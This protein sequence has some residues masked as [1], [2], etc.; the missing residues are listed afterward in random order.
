M[1]V[2]IQ[3]CV[4][5]SFNWLLLFRGAAIILGMIRW[6]L[7]QVHGPSPFH[8]LH[9][10][11]LPPQG[12]EGRKD[13]GALEYWDITPHP[14]VLTS[15]VNHI[16]R[17]CPRTSCPLSPPHPFFHSLPPLTLSPSDLC[18]SSVSSFLKNGVSSGFTLAAS[19]GIH[20]YGPVHG[21]TLKHDQINNINL[22]PPLTHAIR[23]ACLKTLT[24]L[25]I[26]VGFLWTSASS[27]KTSILKNEIKHPVVSDNLKNPG[28][29]AQMF[30]T[31]VHKCEW[32]LAAE[33]PQCYSFLK[34]SFQISSSHFDVL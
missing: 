34:S 21:G 31:L 18:V 17:V 27:Y 20:G 5:L 1:S 29:S 12:H 30:W 22:S 7:P 26:R 24:V 10:P 33:K 32:N 8:C 15:W 16:P 9:N 25:W 13:K 19:R 2:R 4:K 28:G 3:R 6:N 23:S 14:Q 11:K